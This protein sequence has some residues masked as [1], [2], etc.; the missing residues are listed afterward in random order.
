MTLA[1]ALKLAC[2]VALLCLIAGGAYAINTGTLVVDMPVT[3]ATVLAVGDV[4]T[5]HPTPAYTVT[6]RIVAIGKDG[7]T[8]KG[9]ANPSTDVGAIQPSMVAGRVAFTVPYGGYVAVFFQ[10]PALVVALLALVIGL[11]VVFE[12]KDDKTTPQA[13][14]TNLGGDQP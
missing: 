9:D 10:Q 12:L 2:V 6:H 13:S 8:T 5:F 4:I 3:P 1:R 14:A 11:A 7:I